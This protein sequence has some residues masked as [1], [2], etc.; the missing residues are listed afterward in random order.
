[1]LHFFNIMNDTTFSGSH[2]SNSHSFFFSA[3][4][5]PEMSKRFQESSSLESPTAKA[6]ACCLVSRESV[7]VG[8]N[9][10]SNPQSPVST[11]DSQVRTWE[12]NFG[13]PRVRLWFSRFWRSLRNACLG[14]PR[15]HAKSRSE[16]KANSGTMKASGKQR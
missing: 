15:V 2:F 13:K 7:S 9:Y 10:S 3:G 11:R 1:M 5:Q 14:K 16:L 4:K 6:R 12:A 8:Q